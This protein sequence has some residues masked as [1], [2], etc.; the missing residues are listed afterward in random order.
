MTETVKTGDSGAERGGPDCGRAQDSGPAHRVLGRKHN[1]RQLCRTTFRLGAGHDLSD[2][3]GRW[4]V[5]R[6]VVGTAPGG[7][8]L[9]GAQSVRKWWRGVAMDR[10]LPAPGLRRKLSVPR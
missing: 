2:F 9:E 4:C 3:S 1:V 8:S 7:H 5:K 6:D 10:L